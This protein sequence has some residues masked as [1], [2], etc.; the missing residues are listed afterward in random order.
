MRAGL[1]YTIDTAELSEV[2]GAVYAAE[3]LGN[4]NSYMGDLLECAHAT[5][6]N[7]FNEEVTATAIASGS[8]KHMYEWGTIGINSGRSSR[9]MSPTNPAARLWRNDLEGF[10]RERVLNYTF[11]PSTA[12][13]P[14][15]TVAKTGVS[16]RIL[17][18]L[19]RTH[20]FWNKAAVMELGTTVTIAPKHGTKL[21]I[22]FYGEP[23]GDISAAAERRGYM[24]YAGE[25][26][27]QPGRWSQGTFTTYW[28]R[29]W[30]GRGFEMMQEHVEHA[31]TLDLEEEMRITPKA[32]PLPPSPNGFHAEVAASQKK[33]EM[34]M[35]GKAKTR[36]K[37]KSEY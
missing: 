21:F 17:S 32:N 31:L 14:M 16:S 10:G 23:Q 37:E 36:S 18:M 30:N 1:R 9:R 28:T 20:I 26:E 4:D 29:F 7:V 27:V 34:R 35:R 8:F 12:T 24:M 13:V 19:N 33:S 5:T 11:L 2:I 22:P 15:P 6:A 25:V 3:K